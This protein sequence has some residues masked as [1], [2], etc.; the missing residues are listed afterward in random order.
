[1]KKQY[2]LSNNPTKILIVDDN[3]TNVNFLLKSCS[4]LGYETCVVYNGKE[5][6]A[7][8]DIEKIDLVLLDV[9]M[10]VMDGLVALEAIKS[11]QKFDSI[12]IIM[13]SAFDEMKYI[14]KSVQLGAEDYIAKPVNIT[15]LEARINACL[16]KKHA[17]DQVVSL[18][19]V[20]QDN[21]ELLKQTEATRDNLSHMIVHD[22]NNP[23]GVILGNASMLLDH[24]EADE[25][26]DESVL[27]MI[28]YVFSA[29]KEMTM[30][31]Q[32]L[33]DISKLEEKAMPVHFGSVNLNALCQSI[34]DEMAA[35]FSLKRITFDFKNKN[36]DPIKLQSDQL[37]LTRIIKNLL[38]NAL[39]YSGSGS[40]VTLFINKNDDDILITVEDDGPGI[41]D[42][43]K[44]KVFEKFFQYEMKTQGKKS[45]AG[46]GLAFCK[47][48]VEALKGDI[49]V[50]SQEGLGAKFM[51]SFTKESSFAP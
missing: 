47:L 4:I 44:S 46:L 25:T 39:K 13:V 42:H 20:L 8:L 5:A 43:M 23:L 12:P 14:I 21:L 15:L 29:S 19:K 37:L 27:K 33:L 1:M 22:L 17:H 6:L 3:Q 30:M 38:A 26:S 2:H 40:N 41:P 31:V 48:A 34:T 50:E 24:F 16:E 28:K 35:Q 11:Q 18:N 10:P 9:M 45:G 51:I 7:L 36:N 32:S 49:Q